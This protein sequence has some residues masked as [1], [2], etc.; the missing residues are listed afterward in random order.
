MRNDKS[1]TEQRGTL[2]VE[3]IAMLGLIA[4][5]TPT[6]YKKSAER[7]QEIQDINVASQAR[8]MNSVIDTFIKTNFSP[9]MW[10][11]SSD[12]SATVEISFDD[13]Q[14]GY[15][16]IGYSSYVPFGYNPSDLKGYGAP[17]VYVHRDRSTL[18]SYIVYPKQADPGRKRAARLASLVGANGGLVSGI[19]EVQG[20][21]GAWYLDSSMVDELEI[22]SSI[23]TEN[24]LVITSDEPVSMS[25]ED[26]VKFLYRVPPDNDGNTEDYYHNTMVTDLYLGGHYEPTDR[27]DW[28]NDFYSVFN[29][30]KLTMN[31]DCNREFVSGHGTSSTAQHCDP[32][33]ADLYIGKPHG[34][35]LQASDKSPGINEG[36]TGAAWIYGNLSALSDNF[37][38]FREGGGSDGYDADMSR[39]SSA[40][41]VLQFARMHESSDIEEAIIFRAEN[42]SGSARVALL[43]DFVQVRQNGSSITGG[44]V[45]GSGFD[46]LV[47]NSSDVGGEGAF[48]HAFNAGNGNMVYINHGTNDAA[49]YINRQGGRVYING[50]SSDVTDVMETYVNDEGGLFKAGK[51]G[52]WIAATGTKDSAR[53]DLLSGADLG[54]GTGSDDRIFTVGDEDET[55]NHM[56]W[57]NNEKVSLRGGKIL[58]YSKNVNSDGS[59]A[60]G[61]MFINAEFDSSISTGAALD[62]AVALNSRY[63]DIFGTTYIGS[64]EMWSTDVVDGQFSRNWTLGVAGS[65][66]VDDL[67]WARRSWLVNAGMR[68]LH[69]GYE[70]FS[71]YASD[72]TRNGAWLNAYDDKVVI[73]NRLKA[74]NASSS[75]AN[76]NDTMFMA[77]SSMVMM[78]DTEGAWARLE[79]GSAR[80]GTYGNFF[81]ADGGSTVAS[82]SANVV[83]QQLVNIYT[84]NSEDSSFVNIQ[85]DA[86]LLGGHPGAGSTY[87]NTIAAKAKW[88]SILTDGTKPSSSADDDVQF[89]A[90]ADRV[91][92]RYVDFEVE[93]D[94]SIARFRVLPNSDN[95]GGDRAN[96]QV[97]GSFHVGGNDV[98]HIASNSSNTAGEDDDVNRHAMFEVDPEYVSVWAKDK[99]S[100]NYAGRGSSSSQYYAMLKI[101]PYDID[102]TATGS[103]TIAEDASVYIRKGAI[104]LEAS[105]GGDHAS[106]EGY[107]YI[108]ANRLVSNAGQTIGSQ[109]RE[110][111]VS[112]GDTAQYDQYMVNPAY[113]SVMHDI[114]LTTRGGARLSDVLPDFVLKGVYNVI[115]DRKEGSHTATDDT[116]GSWADPFVG[117][118]PYAMCPPGY[119]N[120]AT[121]IPISFN[122]G[123]AGEVVNPSTLG[124]GSTSSKYVVNPSS[125][126]AKI[127]ANAETNQGVIYPEV[128]Q[129]RSLIF[130]SIYQTDDTFSSFVAQTIERTEGWFWGLPAVYDTSD[131]STTTS[132]YRA[133]VASSNVTTGIYTKDGSNWYEVAHPLY[134]QQNTWLKTSLDSD[135]KGWNSYMGFLYATADWA[136]VTGGISA[137]VRSN[138]NMKGDN[139]DTTNPDNSANYVWNLFPVPTST[140]EGH[141][142][143]YCYF[144]R[145]A[146]NSWGGLVDQVDQ[147]AGVN[148]SG[149]FYSK[150]QKNSSFVERLNDPTLKYDDPW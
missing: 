46:F 44:A 80:I 118:L 6:L 144:D 117:I 37:R 49:T 52:A 62:G 58:A 93:D 73:R 137:P 119:K 142:T 75:Y 150:G 111:G 147:L 106:D 30:R 128:T 13:N 5:V 89:F 95:V 57:A 34:K 125:R 8:T 146:F 40:Y 22:D 122:V 42:P 132:D 65:A 7:L 90:D 114:K 67:L 66:W 70:S 14:S 27:G 25:H 77:Q 32:M 24:S 81:F 99:T 91:R 86:L 97:N 102:G 50:G 85:N 36:N 61:P 139:E 109:T 72:A 120:M 43:D 11:M 16:D 9:L 38:L 68:E 4:L 35:F 98:I 47:G 29:V 130:N 18:V 145:T 113:T 1:R 10:A 123:Q 2:L 28:G 39:L 126:Q 3:A 103:T 100:G 79:S 55:D 54:E 64:R 104:E 116:N 105:T 127:L 48:I 101:N 133:S 140:L 45:S 53:V 149:T 20:T 143:V 88:F 94:S 92:T 96:V 136:D 41:D 60:G 108:K 135:T 21:G 110:A 76:E 33:V 63:T 26:N 87:A 115:N 74:R 51:S 31:T 78:N 148:S 15:F 12:A 19:K 69:A 129:A 107:G 84:A 83:G 17:R 134:F 56:M 71:E 121:I 23:L 82:G 141:A 138:H 59:S 131:A 124:K 112:W